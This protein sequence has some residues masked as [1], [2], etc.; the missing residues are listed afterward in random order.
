MRH[1]FKTA[2]LAASSLLIADVCAQELDEEVVVTAT[3]THA[4]KDR[5][6]AEIVVID[7]GEA[8]G[9][10]LLTLDAALADTPGL[11]APR[12][13]PM[14]QQA[15]LFSSG[16]ESNHTLV[17][18]DGVRLDDP[19]T[20]EGIFDAGQD[21]LGDAGRI[22]IVRGPMSALYG[23]GALGGVV[24]VLPRRGGE[25]AF[26]PRLEA[27]FGSFDTISATAGMD[28][29]L[30]R[31]RYAV[32]A[33]SFASNGYDIVPER[34]AT[35]T[36][37]RDGAAMTTL[38]GVFD[39][40]ASDSIALDLLVRERQA[41]ADYDPGF[42]GNIGENPDAQ[43]RQNDTR[44]W[45]LGASS[46]PAQA[47]TLRLAGGML[48]TDRVLE[49]AGVTGDEYHGERAFAEVS[50]GWRGANWSVLIGAEQEDE[51]IEAVSFG[52]SIDGEQTHRGAY[53]TAHGDIGP[54]AVTAALRRDAFDGFGAQT[55]WRA[56]VAYNFAT[57]ARIYAAYGTS[58]RAPSLYE[59]FVPFFGAAGLEPES[60]TSWEIGGESSFAMFGRADGVA[61]RALYRGSE[62][63]DLIGF[64]GFSYAN[65]DRATIDFAEAQLSIRPFD[66][67]IGRLA[68]SNTDAQDAST[69]QALQ[70][71]P[72]RA[73][74]A[75]LAATQGP[76][77]A[78]ISWREIGARLDT[79][80]DD[81]GL[82]A[83][84][85]GVDAYSLFRATAS[86]T[87]SESVQV[88]LSADNLLDETYEPVNGFAGAPRSLLF[89]IRV[90]P[91]SNRSRRR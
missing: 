22:E 45:R 91:G 82:F 11:Q 70:R 44:L 64:A 35:H 6:P 60:A 1:V 59:R 74:S 71:R 62:V 21:L 52:A 23:S 13:G 31:L 72:R 88:F 57:G 86:W 12:T 30:G 80:Y 40:A 36:G 58:Y 4:A 61:V 65:V 39:F 19:S 54:L 63:D 73:W 84:V 76:L 75:S 46:T 85:G 69:G 56:G 38:T 17:L 7:A 89:G 3:R 77:S 20:P 28:G 37:E 29:T 78:E 66:W 67:L 43:V 32:T 81:L 8:R 5:L 55:T 79:T 90:E 87:V 83:G 48:T 9:R 26:N 42:F 47:F 14:G 18:F 34:I 10:G 16:S 27:A 41:H 50:A 51:D 24:N 2:L 25:G 49:D 53:A 33:D 68:Y 15:S